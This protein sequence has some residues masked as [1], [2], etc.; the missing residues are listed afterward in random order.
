[1]VSPLLIEGVRRSPK[2]VSRTSEFVAQKM[3]YDFVNLLTKLFIFYAIS[4]LISKYMEAVIYFQGGISTIAKVLGIGIVQSDQLP[5]QW[6]ELF[7]S[8]TTV[9]A[10]PHIQPGDFNPPGWD[11][12]YQYG[13]VEHQQQEP[14]LFPDK[15]IKY[16]FWDIVNAIAIVYVA[17]Q[18]YKYYERSSKTVEGTD[19]LTLS[20][21]AF[22]VLFMGVLSFSKILN[23]FGFNKF[24]EA[25]K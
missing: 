4:F 25:N 18:G 11:R 14:H 24:Q 21:F 5:K 6:V 15:P 13:S 9:D 12:P 3:D 8:E 22:L 2:A 20:I 23:K 17:W 1:M 10:Q 19:L 7:V 16:K